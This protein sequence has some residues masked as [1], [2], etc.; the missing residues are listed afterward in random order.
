MRN[1]SVT[2]A[3]SQADPARPVRHL[4]HVFP[5]FAA[6]GSELRFVALVNALQRKY[7]HTLVAMDGNFAAAAGI[8][9]NLDCVLETL[10]VRKS[11]GIGLANLRHER[12]LLRRLRPDLL[13]THNWGSIE[14]ALANWAFPFCPHIHIEH[15]F[16]PDKSPQRQHRR[17]VIARRLLLS[18]CARIVV[19]SLVLVDV[20]TRVWRLSPQRILYLPNGIDCDRFAG[21]PDAALLAE[22]GIADDAPVVGT[23][24]VLRPKISAV[25]CASSPPC[26]GN[27]ARAWSSSGPGPSAKS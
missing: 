26:R 9:K 14:W 17:R 2:P 6:G 19:P 23:V 11:R 20:A 13:L 24:A 7:R 12:Q 3:I 18:H 4:L 1:L 21:P 25:S 15:G 16:G 5:S 27:W 10:P 22:L 8:D